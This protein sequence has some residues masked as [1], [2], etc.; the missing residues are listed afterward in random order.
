M[1][2]TLI[3]AYAKDS[4]GRNVIGNN[5]EIPWR[6]SED[7]KR[8]KQFTLNHPVIMGRKTYESIPERFRPLPDRT[9][10]VVSKTLNPEMKGILVARTIED[11]LTLAQAN[12]S[13]G[14]PAYVIGGE[15][16]YRVTINRDETTRLEITEVKVTY[17]GDAFFPEINPD[18]WKEANRVRGENRWYDFVSYVRRTV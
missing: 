1:E 8:F 7:M 10:I 4:Q 16:I 6:I 13:Q 17:E 5:G 11:A 3:A 18:I 2:L 9:N 14:E 15:Q 12:C